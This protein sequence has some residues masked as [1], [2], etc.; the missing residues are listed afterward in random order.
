MI[1]SKELNKEFLDGLFDRTLKPLHSKN[2]RIIYKIFYDKQKFDHLTTH[3]I[4]TQLAEYSITLNKKEINGW[5][6]SLQEA[7]L[8]VKLDERGKPIASNY[9]NRY[10]FDLWKLTETGLKV[11][12]RISNLMSVEKN[13]NLPH[14]SELTPSL[15]HEL[16]DLYITVKVLTILHEYGGSMSYVNLRKRLAVDRE[17]LAVYSWPDS[18][19]AENPLFEVK[20]K[21]LTLKGKIYKLFGWLSEQDLNFTLTENGRKIAEEIMSKEPQ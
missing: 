11:G 19:H 9:D 5:L 1:E 4:E 2:A 12:Y 6:L 3:D 18:S 16:E 14:L 8:I 17:K 21:P 10:T 13:V 15:I 7:G 20:I